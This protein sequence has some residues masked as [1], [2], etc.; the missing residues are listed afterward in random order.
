MG[1]KNNLMKTY[2]KLLL[3]IMAISGLS[4]CNFYDEICGD[5][6]KDEYLLDS[7]PILPQLGDLTYLRI[8][9]DGREDSLFFKLQKLDTVINEYSHSETEKNNNE[10][11]CYVLVE[12]QRYKYL[13]N[14]DIELTILVNANLYPVY[15]VVLHSGISID[16][17]YKDKYKGLNNTVW[18]KSKYDKYNARFQLDSCMTYFLDWNDSTQLKRIK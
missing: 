8:A 4:S 5:E 14:N 9:K 2:L 1:I 18:L 7:V 10:R 6:S 17:I 16:A 12:S 13:A 15:T 11:S 3:L